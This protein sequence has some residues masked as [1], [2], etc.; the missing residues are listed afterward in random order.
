MTDTLTNNSVRDIGDGM[1]RKRAAAGGSL[2]S[3]LFCACRQSL[4]LIVR[5]GRRSEM[6]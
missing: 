2:C 1:E 4:S 5:N 6:E 3:V